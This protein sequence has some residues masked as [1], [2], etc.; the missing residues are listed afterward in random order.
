MMFTFKI[1]FFTMSRHE[2]YGDGFKKQMNKHLVCDT[3]V[4]LN[5]T[6]T[7]VY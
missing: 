3:T 6:C 2:C 5:T 4:G 7:T 1:L